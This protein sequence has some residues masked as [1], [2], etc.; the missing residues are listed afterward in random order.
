MIPSLSRVLTGR[1][2][3]SG[4]GLSFVMAARLSAVGAIAHFAVAISLVFPRLDH[5]NL[6]VGA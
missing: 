2:Q 1:L 3:C 4:L 5:P 6:H